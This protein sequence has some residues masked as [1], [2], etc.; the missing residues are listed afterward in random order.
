MAESVAAAPVTDPVR[1]ELEALKKRVDE[2]E[3]RQATGGGEIDAKESAS[4]T[5]KPEKDDESFDVG[6]ALRFNF[7]LKDFDEDQKSRYGDMGLDLFRL[8]VDGRQGNIILSAE[9][10]FYAYMNTIHHGWMGY[11]FDNGNQLQVG[12]SQVPFGLLPYDSHN[13]WFG[14]P[15]Y[16]GLGDDY[17]AG[18]KY[19]IDQKPW[20]IQLAF[21]KNAEL[22]NPGNLDRYSYD[23]VT[24]GATK[25][26]ET[27]TF[28]GRFAYLFGQGGGCDNE[29]GVSLQWGEVY[30]QDTGK[31]GSQW[32]SA[33]HL[34]SRC[35]RWN[36]QLEAGRYEYSPKNPGSVSDKTVTFGAF[37]SSQELASKANFGVANL[38]YNFPAGG[39]GVDVLTCY[40]D[41]SV[42]S[43]DASGFD[44]S[45]LNTTGCAIG[46]GPVFTYVDIIQGKNMLFFGNGSLAGGGSNDWKT[47]LNINLGYYW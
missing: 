22:A 37:G 35:G 45:Y 11:D 24:T 16:I 27:N 10:R 41:F 26:Q 28:N 4:E 30:N 43:K 42:L 2:L 13:F 39:L 29:A 32:A 44:N 5:A 36:F 6:G 23:L 25:N 38:A 3:S 20:N 47:R 8:N 14:V 12:I 21:Y 18:V 17:D 33:A 7:V 46:M 19:V 31:T 40:N 9:Y 1:Q 15:Y 34:D